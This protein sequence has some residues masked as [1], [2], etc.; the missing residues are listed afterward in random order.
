M[1]KLVLSISSLLLLAVQVNAQQPPAKTAVGGGEIRTNAPKGAYSYGSSG[2]VSTSVNATAPM[3]YGAGTNTYTYSADSSLRGTAYVRSPKINGVGTNVYS[4]GPSVN[5]ST[6]VN[7]NGKNSTYTYSTDNQDQD[8]SDDP[9]RAKTFS[10]SFNIDK[11]DKVSLSNIYGSIT[12]KTWDKNEIKVDADIKAYANTEADAQKLLDNVSI[13]ASKEGDQVVFKTNMQERLGS[14]GRGT[15]NGKRWRKEVK[16]YYT[17]YMPK[18]NALTVSQNYGSIT[19]DD[20]SGPTS[21]K[22]THGALTGGDLNSS[23][24]YISAAY[25]TVKLKDVNAARINH[26]YGAGLTIGTIGTLDLDAHYIPI[27]ITAIKNSGKI[28]HEYGSGI[29][30]TSANN[31]TINTHYVKTRIATLTGTTTANLEY[32]DLSIGKIEGNAKALNVNAEYSDINLGFGPSYNANFNVSTA[33]AGFKYGSGVTAK[34]QGDERS[35]ATT[36][37]Y[38]GQIGKGGVS[39]VS[40]KAEYGS[41]TFK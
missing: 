28:D 39:N 35:Y 18:G 26:E 2:N 5:A 15:V 20:F 9:T 7:V 12:I 13:N 10:K 33:Y 31:L 16:I 40:V 11:N 22:V 32:A 41:V 1:K 36:K 23:N 24:N 37:N 27:N 3:A 8:Q 34:K 4:Y 38:A 14:W 19:M 6:S 17:V 21:I 29:N 25:S 30:I